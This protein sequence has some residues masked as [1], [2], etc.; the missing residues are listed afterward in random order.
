[1]CQ[2]VLGHLGIKMQRVAELSLNQPI[3]NVT[4]Y[5]SLVDG[6]VNCTAMG[7]TGGVPTSDEA[8]ALGDKGYFS[9]QCRG[10]NDRFWDVLMPYGEGIYMFLGVISLIGVIFYFV[11]SSVSML[12][13]LPAAIVLH[14]DH[15]MC[16]AESVHRAAKCHVVMS[17]GLRLVCRRHAQRRRPHPLSA[18][19]AHL[20]GGH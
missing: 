12:V 10:H 15:A 18:S 1:M 4:H 13:R 16:A 2:G 20:L 9:L 14:S 8:I 19:P 3:V 5:P 6:T 7:Y 17:A 11:T